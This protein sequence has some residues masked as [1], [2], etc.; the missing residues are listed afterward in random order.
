MEDSSL[1][2]LEL[3]ELLG[4]LR[5]HERDFVALIDDDPQLKRRRGGL[6]GGLVIA[7]AR[8]ELYR[9]EKLHQLLAK[10]IVYRKAT[11]EVVS[12]PLVKMFNHDRCPASDAVSRQIIERGGHRITFPEKLD[13]TMVQLFDADGIVWLGT[14][15]TLEGPE[16]SPQLQLARSVLT[17]DAPDLLRPGTAGKCTLVFELVHPQ[18]RQITRYGARESMVLV[19]IYDR[20]QW[21]Y[22]R[23]ADVIAFAKEHNL[24]RPALLLADCETDI[25]ESEIQRLRTVLAGNTVLPEG[26][27][28]CFENEVQILHRVKVKMEAYLLRLSARSRITLKTV[29]QRIWHCPELHDWEAYR[30]QVAPEEELET[31]HKEHHD[32]VVMWLSRMKARRQSAETTAATFESEKGERLPELDQ[33]RAAYLKDAVQWCKSRACQEFGLVMQRLRQRKLLLEDVMLTDPIYPGFREE[34]AL[35]IKRHRD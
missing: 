18:T 22:W 17:R 19:A 3:P 23:T 35:S 13:G 29:T 2:V 25:L 16:E 21:R 27:V 4:R 5:E 10:G 33:K 15:S 28:V 24:E 11:L 34:V 9:P 14:R 1:Q 20:L 6:N 8:D 32:A 31:L 7:N 26:S 30:R 12:L